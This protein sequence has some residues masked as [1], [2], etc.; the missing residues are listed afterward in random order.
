MTAPSPWATTIRP[1]ATP[2]RAT[3]CPRAWRTT[4]R[5]QHQ[6]ATGE[7]NRGQGLA[8]D[9]RGQRRGDH[10]FEGG[11]DGGGGRAG[12]LQAR[13]EGEHRQ[14]RGD[15]GDTGQP[16]P[17]RQTEAEVDAAG[18]QGPYAEGA[19]GA[20]HHQRRQHHGWQPVHD[21]V[22]DEDV[23]GVGD[24]GSE[25]PATPRAA[26]GRAAGA[27]QDQQ[28]S[29][30][31]GH[32][33][34]GPPGGQPVPAEQHRRHGDQDGIRVE[35]QGQQRGVHQPQRREVQA[36]LRGVPDGTQ[37]EGGNQHP[38]VRRG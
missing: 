22:G 8:E 38:A 7:L 6:T 9:E 20:G 28:R 30:G 23:D 27:E 11:Q 24:R 33:R 14:D 5:A 2:A 31:C 1:S 12:P 32:Q 25:G 10:R 35:D 13:E 29:A 36:R 15:D 26:G 37:P 21:S 3:W 34:G 4:T 18:N 19:G 16:E 17:S